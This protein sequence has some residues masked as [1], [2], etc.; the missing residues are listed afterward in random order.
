MLPVGYFYGSRPV[1]YMK[2]SPALDGIRAIAIFVVF[3]FHI[4]PNL[5][6]GGFI[7]VDVFFVLSGF[8][9]TSKIV[10]D[11]EH[12]TFSIG[13]FYL[14]RISRL[15]PNALVMVFT[16]TV[17]CNLL[18]SPSVFQATAKHSLWAMFSASNIYVYHYLGGY[19]GDSAESA[20][21]THTW[22]LG[23]EEQFYLIYPL[24]LLVLAK[25]LRKFI[26]VTIV[27]TTAISFLACLWGTVSHPNAAFYL[28]PFRAWELMLGGILS[29]SIQDG[30]FTALISKSRITSDIIGS[31][32]FISLLTSLYITRDGV[33]FP[34]WYSLYPTLAT[35]LLIL[36]TR[37]ESSLTA[38][39]LSIK[40]LTVI[41]KLSYSIY[42]WH[43][44]LIIIF[45]KMDIVT[46]H[47]SG[48]G[49]VIGAAL[50]VFVAVFSY[51][52]VEKPM[53]YTGTKPLIRNSIF[54]ATFIVV[55]SYLVVGGLK[56][57]NADVADVFDTV[58]FSGTAYD[59]G[60]SSSPEPNEALRY[61]D[62]KFMPR[63]NRTWKEGGIIRLRG[64]DKPEVVVFG[65][66][67]ALMYSKV[68]DDICKELNVSVAFFP[69]DGGAPALFDNSNSSAILGPFPS[70]SES[71]LYDEL[72]W[73]YVS[74]WNP[75]C[76]LVI[77]RWDQYRNVKAFELSMR[78]FLDKFAVLDSQIVFFA[79]VPVHKIGEQ[80]NLREFV[81]MK[82]KNAKQLPILVSDDS[83]RLRKEIATAAEKLRREYTSLSVV[84]PDSSFYLVDGS[85]R[86]LNGRKFLYA[87]D[88]HLSDD[89]SM[90]VKSKIKA[91]V[92][93]GLT[94]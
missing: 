87:D 70:K 41:G 86:Y 69:V 73:Q 27:L 59:V 14:R 57:P 4:Q 8:L 72:R 78:S 32:G 93:A 52:I 36:S 46:G 42:L 60:T 7:G 58:S 1:Q 49:A 20:P 33:G 10:Q 25:H 94:R 30:R 18:L 65:S 54:V 89:G 12:G 80:V 44:P 17:I 90:F 92:E 45:K 67:H 85:I 51:L 50:S 81:G 55:S 84:R 11:I 88:D 28:L 56:R 34:G 5:I 77:D 71:R 48:F 68:I 29:L 26:T 38:I 31:V 19:W 74:K 64:T 82:M 13:K 2:Y 79:Q 40:P 91:A 16:T 63:S 35:C 6:P 43:W 76:V 9:I 21:L 37:N 66:S 53:R 83:E 62:V 3:L 15:V 75:K 47:P 61:Y 23:I 24:F 22:S 39:V